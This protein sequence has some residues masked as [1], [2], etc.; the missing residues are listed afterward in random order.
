M[1]GAYRKKF[2]DAMAAD[3]LIVC[4]GQERQSRIWGLATS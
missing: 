4:S 3:G 2:F 1:S